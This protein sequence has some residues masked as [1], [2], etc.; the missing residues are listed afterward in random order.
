MSTKPTLDKDGNITNLGLK[1][2]L[3]PGVQSGTTF[4]HLYV[5][6]GELRWLTYDGLNYLEDY[7]KG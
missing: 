1:K 4:G 5:Q 3:P 7:G 2:T 6:M